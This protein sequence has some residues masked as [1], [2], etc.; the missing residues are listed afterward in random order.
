VVLVARVD[1]YVAHEPLARALDDVDRADL[2]AGA[3]DRRRHLPERA[4]R[5][6]ELDP[7]SQAV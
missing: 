3:P 2:S 6:L 7:E 4:W 5:V 1:G